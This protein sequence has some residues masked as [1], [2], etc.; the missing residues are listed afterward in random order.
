MH[1]H[2]GAT[3]RNKGVPSEV[4][5]LT[6]RVNYNDLEEL[7]AAFEKANGDVAA[8]I[9]EPMTF[10]LP[11]EGYLE[12]VRNLC[13]EHGALLVFDEVITGFRFSLGGAQKMF[14]VTPDIAAF[15]K[16]MGNGMPVS[17]VVGRVDVMREMEEVFFSG[18]FGDLWDVI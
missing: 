7:K 8:V 14:G 16:A 9:M 11:H 17:A 12:T 2:V 1:G 13:D 15:G 5:A 6:K 18:T 3:S 10:D 4:S